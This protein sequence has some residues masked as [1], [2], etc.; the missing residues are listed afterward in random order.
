MTLGLFD[1]RF[2]K[3]AELPGLQ[4]AMAVDSD[5]QRDV[6]NALRK[7]RQHSKASTRLVRFAKRDADPTVCSKAHS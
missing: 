3:F 4:L 1:Q 7:R 2:G 6:A 5:R